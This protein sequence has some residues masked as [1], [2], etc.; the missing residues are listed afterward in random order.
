MI[1]LS[2]KCLKDAAD[3]WCWNLVPSSLTPL[4][5]ANNFNYLEQRQ[6]L[7]AVVRAVE[8]NGWTA[9]AMGYAASLN[10]RTNTSSGVLATHRG[11]LSLVSDLQTIVRR[12]MQGVR[13][14]S[15]LIVV[16]HSHGTV[17]SHLLT[18]L[19][20]ALPIEI[21]VDLD[22]VC[23]YWQ[24]DNEGDF[25]Q[26]GLGDLLDFERVCRTRSSA[27]GGDASDLQNVVFGNVRYNLD[28]HSS[29]L[30]L[31]DGTD[32]TRPDGSRAGIFSA[33]FPE[34]H[35]DVTWPTSATM[36][37]VLQGVTNLTRR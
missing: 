32:N 18:A 2:G 25:R 3:Q 5:T 10:D 19:S 29:D 1:G 27:L 8:K 7:A 36:T 13:N 20:P 6:T 22:G 24:T 21:Q 14:P 11:Y 34:N 16:G 4:N 17:W 12:D 26:A 28:V 30:A 37:W 33:A 9:R 35:S 15:R 23:A 31:F